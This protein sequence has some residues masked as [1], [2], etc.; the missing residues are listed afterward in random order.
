MLQSLDMWQLELVHIEVKKLAK[1]KA[2]HKRKLSAAP[3]RNQGD[4]DDLASA[5]GLDISGLLR[6]ISRVRK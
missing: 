4:I 3:P 6:E 2:D 5:Q 1:E